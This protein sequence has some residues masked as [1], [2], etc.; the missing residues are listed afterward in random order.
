MT[1]LCH[2]PRRLPRSHPLPSCHPSRLYALLSSLP[3][4]TSAPLSLSASTLWQIALALVLRRYT[5]LINTA[6]HE[7]LEGS[8]KPADMPSMRG[9]EVGAG[10]PKAGNN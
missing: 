3:I 9:L 8:H 7:M 4:A 1:P 2:P 6:E 10:D 5:V